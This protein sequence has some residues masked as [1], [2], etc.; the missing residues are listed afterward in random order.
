MEDLDR[1]SAGGGECRKQPFAH[2]S[3]CW[4]HDHI[5]EVTLSQKENKMSETARVLWRERTTI[6]VAYIGFRL[7]WSSNMELILR[8]DVCD[9][10]FGEM[11][12]IIYKCY[13]YRAESSTLRFP[14]ISQC[15]I[16]SLSMAEPAGPDASK[17]GLYVRME[18]K[19]SK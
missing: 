2:V 7:S 14:A 6:I 13:R 19:R 12:D 9:Q 5:M 15:V 3:A 17:H 16:M 10:V 11:K 4:L 8:W 18:S 1:D